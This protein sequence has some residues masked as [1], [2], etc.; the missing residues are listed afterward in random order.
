MLF[1]SRVLDTEHRLYP[2]A[3][4][5]FVEGRLA[6]EDGRVRQLDGAAQLLLG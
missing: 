3:A 6:V 4:R 5:W 2:L 1:R